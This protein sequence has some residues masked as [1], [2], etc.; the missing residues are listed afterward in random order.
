MFLQRSFPNFGNAV[1][2]KD[3]MHTEVDNVTLRI[4]A[5]ELNVKNIKFTSEEDIIL[6]GTVWSPIK[7]WSR[8]EI[9]LVGSN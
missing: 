7:D 9:E 1:Y 8:V 4:G 3:V 2:G 5:E 6:L